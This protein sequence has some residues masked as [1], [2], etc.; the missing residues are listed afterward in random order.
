MAEKKLTGDKIQRVLN[1][2]LDGVNRKSIE[3]E[4]EVS[5]T[6]ITRIKQ[7]FPLFFWVSDK[8]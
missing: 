6:A 7:S 8:E 3:F 4:E 1:K 5:Q 2:L